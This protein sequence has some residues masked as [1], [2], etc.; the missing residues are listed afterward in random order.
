MPNSR[1]E[2]SGDPISQ[3]LSGDDLG[4]KQKIH[5]SSKTI[6]SRSFKN[7]YFEKIHLSPTELYL[8]N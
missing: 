4:S 1:T 7:N 8:Q 6:A 5:H 3:D 2:R